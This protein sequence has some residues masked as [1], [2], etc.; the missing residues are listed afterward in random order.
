MLVLLSCS[1]LLYMSVYFFML[2]LDSYLA[3]WFR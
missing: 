1:C 2:C 3:I